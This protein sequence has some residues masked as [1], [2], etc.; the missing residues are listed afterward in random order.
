[1]LK[2]SHF[3]RPVDDQFF[4]PLSVQAY[5]EYKIYLQDISQITISSLSDTWRYM[6]G[7]D[8]YSS[9]KFYKLCFLSIQPPTS[10]PWI[11]K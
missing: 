9:Q 6:W 1:M 11:W 3:A 5:D 8:S 10:L 4:L 7:N 2:G